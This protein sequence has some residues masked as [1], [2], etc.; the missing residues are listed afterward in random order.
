VYLI[1]SIIPFWDI[2]KIGLTCCIVRSVHTTRYRSF[3]KRL[4]Q[5]RK[6]AGLTQSEVAS[7]LNRPQSFIS[8]CESGER[9]VDAVELTEFAEVYR[10]PLVY[11]L[12]DLG[13]R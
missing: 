11:F 8:K 5:A 12:R 9:R 1:D 6:E 10:K 3:L 7:V 13:S 4:R 2:S